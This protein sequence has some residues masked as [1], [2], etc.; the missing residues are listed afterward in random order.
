MPRVGEASTGPPELFVRPAHEPDDHGR[1]PPSTT[2]V[3]AAGLWVMTRLEE[4]AAD[5]ADDAPGEAGVLEDALGEDVGLAADRRHDQ[6]GLRRGR[7][8]PTGSGSTEPTISVVRGQR[9]RSRAE[10]PHEG[11][12]DRAWQERRKPDRHVLPF[13][14]GEVGCHPPTG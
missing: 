8:R 9:E 12:D 7:S 4:V 13:G 10:D 2:R 6:L 1:A 11:N 3:P 5:G 14:S